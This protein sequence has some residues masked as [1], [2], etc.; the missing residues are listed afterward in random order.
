[1][2]KV[3]DKGFRSCRFVSTIV[4]HPV[5]TLY[6]WMTYNKFDE[7]ATRQKGPKHRPP[8]PV[9]ERKVITQH[10]IYTNVS[11]GLKNFFHHFVRLAI[12]NGLHF[13][14]TLS[15]DIDDAQ[16]SLSYVVFDQ[17][18]LFSIT[19]TSVTVGIMT[20]TRQLWSGA[21]FHFREP[22]LF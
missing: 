6:Q 22:R 4:K 9:K 7:G 10:R 15:K 20:N 1:M 5:C 8:C 14:F 3:I 19:C 13:F 16:S 21:N 18:I 17:T 11:R 2:N 12:E